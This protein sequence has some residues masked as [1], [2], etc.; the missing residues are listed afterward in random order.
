MK[1][2]ACTVPPMP[3]PLAS[4]ACNSHYRGRGAFESM[5]A[6]IPMAPGDIAFKCN[7]ATMDMDTGIVTSRRADRDFEHVGPELCAALD[8]EPYSLAVQIVRPCRTGGAAAPRRAC[9]GHGP[10]APA[11]PERCKKAWVHHGTFPGL[12]PWTLLHDIA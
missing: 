6:G 12:M 8:G 10:A 4:P 2:A 7:F 3:A 5:G 9:P 1:C 11:A